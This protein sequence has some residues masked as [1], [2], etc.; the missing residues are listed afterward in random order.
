V[1]SLLNPPGTPR[2]LLVAGALE[3]I[4]RGGQPACQIYFLT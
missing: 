1:L 3:T 2:Q 4:G